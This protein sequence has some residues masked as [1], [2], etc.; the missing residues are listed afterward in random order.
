[1]RKWVA[2]TL[3]VLTMLFS[4]LLLAEDSSDTP[5]QVT[6][7]VPDR[8]DA[9]LQQGLQSAFSQA[10]T[11]MSNDLQVATSPAIKNASSHVSQWVQSYSY[12]DSH[13]AEGQ[14]LLSLQVVFDRAGVAQLLSETKR[15]VASN[16]VNVPSTVSLYVS[17]VQTISDYS[18]ITK[19]LRDNKNVEQVSVKNMNPYSVLLEVKV[20]GSTADFQQALS[21]SNQFSPI[22]SEL[23]QRLAHADL[24]YDWTGNQA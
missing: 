2:M 9:A 4:P 1:M 24:Y 14:P 15:P 6:V 12:T 19:A 23:Q 16:A 18:R 21:A 8:S 10:V 11:D 7:T 3:A 22:A 5:L 13:N 17:G 20:I